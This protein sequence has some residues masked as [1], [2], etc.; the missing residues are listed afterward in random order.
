MPLPLEAAEEA[1]ADGRIIRLPLRAEQVRVE[2][3]TVIRER[4]V[5]RSRH[6]EE[7]ARVAAPVRRERLR[8]ETKM[9]ADAERSDTEPRDAP[10]Q[11]AQGSAGSESAGE[12]DDF[13]MR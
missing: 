5:V 12:D 7:V 2:K 9:D 3:Q 8:V 10:R 6:V 4:V 1:T 11:P 13:R